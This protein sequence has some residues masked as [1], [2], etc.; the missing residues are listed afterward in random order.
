ML[1]SWS[2]EKYY[3]N[4]VIFKLPK[5]LLKYF[6]YAQQWEKKNFALHQP[7]TS[8]V[9]RDICLLIQMQW[10]TLTSCECICDG[11]VNESYLHENFRVKNLVGAV[12]V[13]K[14]ALLIISMNRKVPERWA[15]LVLMAELISGHWLNLRGRNSRGSIFSIYAVIEDGD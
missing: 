6:N 4:A 7:V 8:H 12:F 11:L 2:L 5:P 15:P 13:S 14:L 3:N 9:E 1:S 10:P